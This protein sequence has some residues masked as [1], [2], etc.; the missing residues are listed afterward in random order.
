MAVEVTDGLKIIWLVNKKK[1][2]NVLWLETK[3]DDKD[4]WTSP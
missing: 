1:K 4:S 3:D 2:K